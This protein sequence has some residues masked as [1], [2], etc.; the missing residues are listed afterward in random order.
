MPV[1]MRVEDD[2]DDN[3]ADR[4]RFLRREHKARVSALVQQNTN[5]YRRQRLCE[6]I[7]MMTVLV[8]FTAFR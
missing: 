6:C 2:E 7:T 8:S 4:A 5:F 1:I 3:E